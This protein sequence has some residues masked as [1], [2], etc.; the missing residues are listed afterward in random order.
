MKEMTKAITKLEKT[1]EMKWVLKK[2]A[3]KNLILELIVNKL[4]LIRDLLQTKALLYRLTYQKLLPRIRKHPI[5]KIKALS[6]FTIML[7]KI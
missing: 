3:T 1:R 6:T 2:L 4:N 5:S 7:L